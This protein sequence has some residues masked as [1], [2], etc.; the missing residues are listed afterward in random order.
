MTLEETIAGAVENLKHRR[1]PLADAKI[2]ALELFTEYFP[3]NA[4]IDYLTPARLR[5]F[6]SRWYAERASYAKLHGTSIGKATRG[7]IP[8]PEVLTDSLSFFFDYTGRLFD[9]QR[10]AE[11]LTTLDEMKRGLPQALM[12]T[13]VLSRALS[14]RGGAFGFA[15]FLTSFEGGGHSRYDVDAID[16][17]GSIE[18]YFRILRIEDSSIAAEEI[19]T[20]RQVHPIIFPREVIEH[21]AEGFII[22]LELI[23]SAGGW[24]ILACGFAYPPGTE[25]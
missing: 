15:E 7:E 8:E 17:A 3:P 24:Q 23:G 22:N 1:A 14:E 20:E 11:C 6:L 2:K 9:A 13:T 10:I 4:A 16:G 12:I 21:L 18:G 25:L 19:I 5:D